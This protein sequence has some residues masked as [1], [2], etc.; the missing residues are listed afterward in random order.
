MKIGSLHY[1]THSGLGV[2]AKEFFDHFVVTDVL[3]NQHIRFETHRDW[4]PDAEVIGNR[5]VTTAQQ[6]LQILEAF[7]SKLDILFIF[8]S[9]W[10]AQTLQF[11][12]K[13]KVPIAFMPMYE[14][15][16]YPMDADLF[17]TVSQLDCDFYRRMYPQHRVE[18]LN[19]P[20]NSQIEWR[21]RSQCK[22]FL[23]NGGNGSR[24][25]RNGTQ[26]LIDALPF[27]RSPIELRIKGQGLDLPAVH[28]RRVE[29]INRDLSFSELWGEADAFVFVERFAGLSLPLQEAFASGMLVIAGNRHPINTWLPTTPLVAP[30]GYE[31]LSFVNVPFKSALYDPRHI[32]AKID[33]LYDTDISAYSLAGKAW[34]EEHSWANMKPR[35]LELLSTLLR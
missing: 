14:W 29:V 25:D 31:D 20:T 13:H 6:D 2:L 18:M 11:A 22:S 23:H 27:I 3:I 24:N 30:I 4:Y 12:R 33:A 32:A 5:E 19:V 9:P 10:Y 35:Y 15:T 26:A 16:P 21:K 8:E 1:A 34:A 17:I 28:D 7:I